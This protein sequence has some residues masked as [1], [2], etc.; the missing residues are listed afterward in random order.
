MLNRP[1]LPWVKG[2]QRNAKGRRGTH[3]NLQVPPSW[4]PCP[5]APQT[6]T[7]LRA[8]RYF[9]VLL[10]LLFAALLLRGGMTLG[11]LL[12]VS[13]GERRCGGAQQDRHAALS[14]RH[15]CFQACSTRALTQRM[16][17]FMAPAACPACARRHHSDGCLP[18]PLV[19]RHAVCGHPGCSHALQHI[20]VRIGCRATA[21]AA[22]RGLKCVAPAACVNAAQLA[23][24]R[25]A[26]TACRPRVHP[27]V[28][29]LPSLAS[30]H[31]H[32]SS[33][34]PLLTHASP[35]TCLSSLTPLP[36]PGTWR[37]AP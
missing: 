12:A 20:L 16:R 4:I 30:P 35:H 26:T 1:A 10:L 19:Y 18:P 7:D 21:A 34:T 3:L 32:L 2:R 31:S 28:S 37:T 33:Y 9:S 36:P 14:T 6:Q 24:S 29:C 22:F 8:F 25:V 11:D 27:G 15:P 17:K 13:H 23:C 5:L